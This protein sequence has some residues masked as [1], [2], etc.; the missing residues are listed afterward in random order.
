MNEVVEGGPEWDRAGRA[1]GKAR[2]DPA[3]P[4]LIGCDGE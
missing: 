2:R 4:A 3:A 1:P